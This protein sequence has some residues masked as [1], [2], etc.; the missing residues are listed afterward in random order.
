MCDARCNVICGYDMRHVEYDCVCVVYDL[1]C[2]LTNI[3]RTKISFPHCFISAKRR[4]DTS[5]RCS[6]IRRTHPYWNTWPSVS[7]VKSYH[8]QCSKVIR[9]VRILYVWM[10]GPMFFADIRV[11]ICVIIFMCVPMCAHV[12]LYKNQKLSLFFVCPDSH[13]IPHI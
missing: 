3:I 4:K 6:P 5:Q 9:C 11:L 7:H 1:W 12:C 2:V 10:C 8:S 13:T